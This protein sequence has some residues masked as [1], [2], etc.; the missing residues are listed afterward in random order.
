MERSAG[1]AGWENLRGWGG[2]IAPGY[3]IEHQANA[4]GLTTPESRPTLSC[5]VGSAP[6]RARTLAQ[7][8]EKSMRLTEQQ[9]SFFDTFGFLMF[10]G[11]FAKE[12]DAIT[13][14]FEGLWASHGG[15]HQGKAH[16]FKERS[17]IV[18]FIDQDEHLSSLI[19][20]PRIED[21]L[22]SVLGDDFNYAGSD[23][24]FYVGDTEWALGRVAQ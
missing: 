19:D 24:N 8:E 11:L 1:W 12:I 7:E 10:P 14:S 3:D 17:S 4:C 22:G 15:G 23:G 20:D 16:D 5:D 18:P 6:W 2:D 9:L 21:V 13:D